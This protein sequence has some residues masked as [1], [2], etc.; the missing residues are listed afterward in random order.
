M[1]IGMFGHTKLTDLA[2]SAFRHHEEE[3]FMTFV[4]QSYASHPGEVLNYENMDKH[5][6]R[7]FFL[8]SIGYRQFGMKENIYRAIQEFQRIYKDKWPLGSGYIQFIELIDHHANVP[9]YKDW[10]R[11]AGNW[12]MEGSTIQPYCV[13]GNANTIW[14]GSVISHHSRLDSFN[15][16]SP[17]VTVCGEAVIGSNNF[18]GAGSIICNGVSIGSDNIISAGAVVSHNMANKQMALPGVNR[19]I[20][21]PSI[22]DEWKKLK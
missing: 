4:T 20:T 16:I 13:L 5:F 11:G 15:W 1:T 18:F 8:G 6:I 21:P 3:S 7:S 10:R 19:I 2:M 17:S 12:V 22:L 14:S 9:G